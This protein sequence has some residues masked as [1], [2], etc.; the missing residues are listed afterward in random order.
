MSF[1]GFQSFPL[2]FDSENFPSFFQE[3]SE[4]SQNLIFPT[5]DISNF[6]PS[7]VPSTTPLQLHCQQRNRSFKFA[8]RRQKLRQ[9]IKSETF[10]YFDSVAFQCFVFFAI[11]IE[12]QINLKMSKPRVFVVGVGMTKVRHLDNGCE[13]KV[14]SFLIVASR[15]L[16]T[17]IA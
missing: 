15:T 10:Y 6:T 9:N 2:S 13:Q 7:D 1:N 3:K 5:V 11:L 8:L 14:F 16:E 4:I 17:L 12:H